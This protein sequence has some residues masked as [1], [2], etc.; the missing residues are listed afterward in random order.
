MGKGL[1]RAALIAA[2]L[3]ILSAGPAMAIG[4]SR[5]APPAPRPAMTISPA[6]SSLAPPLIDTGQDGRK[7]RHL[8][9]KRPRHLDPYRKIL[10]RWRIAQAQCKRVQTT[11]L[12]PLPPMP[13]DN[14]RVPETR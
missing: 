1:H 8:R 9:H 3:L 5:A 11:C 7:R 6:A 12:A 14:L 2:S 4:I 13:S 10:V